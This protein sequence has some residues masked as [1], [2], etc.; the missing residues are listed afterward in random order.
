MDL[1]C[2]WAVNGLLGTASGTPLP[3]AK[4]AGRCPLGSSGRVSSSSLLGELLSRT[5]ATLRIIHL[6]A[7]TS[8]FV[9]LGSYFILTDTMFPRVRARAL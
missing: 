8:L 4:L 1:L 9:R 6:Y 7:G 5:S 3:S 2:Y